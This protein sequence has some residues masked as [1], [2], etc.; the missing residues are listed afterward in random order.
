MIITITNRKGGVGKST[1][2]T[3][4]AAGLATKGYRIG[5]VDTDSQG[6][7]A[8]I[9]SMPETNGLYNVMVGKQPL[10]QWVWQVPP[11]HYAV[12]DHPSQGALYLLPSSD[13]TYK[14]PAELQQHEAFL[15]LETLEAMAAQYQLHHIIIDTN[16]T[17]TM[18]DGAVYMASDA[19][20][21]VTECARLSMDGVA[22]AVQQ[23]LQM[24]ASR[25]RFLGRETRILGILPN[26]FRVNTLNHRENVAALA[27]HFP[28]DVWTPIRLKTVYEKSQ[29]EL[30]PVF[31]FAPTSNEANDMWAL[32]E[33]AE[34]VLA[35][36]QTA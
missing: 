23:M 30:K 8:L 31:V 4:L 22:R 18:F 1:I 21:Y 7:A 2:A 27:Q 17:M 29:E 26:K 25:E 19:Y 5:V 14:I 32:V 3:N 28:G 24:R 15:F 13:Q 34:G 12:G 16:P 11:Q 35:S 20:L 6:H 33:H 10:E 9:F 36:W